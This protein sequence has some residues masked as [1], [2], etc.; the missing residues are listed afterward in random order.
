MPIRSFRRSAVLL[1]L[2]GGSLKAQNAIETAARQGIDA[3]NR[4]W[5]EGM[6][7][8]DAKRIAGTYAEDATDCSAAGDCLQGR[9]MIERQIRERIGK[10]GRAVSAS[11]ESKGAVQQGDFVYEWGQ[12]EAAFANGNRIAGRYLT[13]WRRGAG[14]GWEI[15]RNLKIPP[16]GKAQ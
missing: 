4:A 15:W 5:I 1:M 10:L 8:G 9:A 16:D 12:A 11:V 13:V 3:G 14:G 6:K 2:L 7:G